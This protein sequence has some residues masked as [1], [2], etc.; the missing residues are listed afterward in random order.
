MLALASATTSAR[1][2]P[3]RLSKI[4]QE[5]HTACSSIV[6]LHGTDV[7]GDVLVENSSFFSCYGADRRSSVVKTNLTIRLCAGRWRVE[8]Q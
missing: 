8:I 2:T 1:A 5:T 4:D 7:C 3:I 6:L